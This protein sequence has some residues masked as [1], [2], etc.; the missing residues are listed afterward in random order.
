[1]SLVDSAGAV[2]SG[3]ELDVKAIDHYMKQVVPGLTGELKITQFPGGASNLTYL[4]SYDDR[5]FVLRRPPFGHKAKSAHDMGREFRVM[6]GLQAVYPYVPKMVGFCDDHEV[7]GS[8]FYVMERLRGIIL[9]ADVPKNLNLSASDCTTLCHNLVD[10]LVDLH[11]IN[12]K[13]TTLKELARPGDYV[14]RQI[15]G[16][17]DRYLKSHTDDAPEYTEVMAWLK[18]RQPSQIQQCLV[19]NDYRFDNLVLDPDNPMNIIGVLDWEMATIGDP[20]MDLG[21]SLA[22]WIQQDDPQPLHVLRRQPTHLPG[23]LSRQQVVDYYL[24]KSGLDIDN[25]DFYEVYGVFRLVVII[26]QIYYRYY[27]GQTQDKRFAGFIQMVKYLEG[28]LRDK[29]S[30]SSLS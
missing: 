20:L 25:F 7:I 14:E 12:W 26:Q 29:I 17:C 27:H 11:Q 10:R 8:E 2:R 6:Q 22:Y 19:H 30:A 15:N 16:W 13:Q 5:E 18:E 23:M 24:E 9:R 1:M 21:N 28:Y 4:L 3:E